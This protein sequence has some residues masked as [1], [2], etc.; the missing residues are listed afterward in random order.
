MESNELGEGNGL[1]GWNGSGMASEI[2]ESWDSTPGSA[3]AGTGA[4]CDLER[5]S[6]LEAAGVSGLV[7]YRWQKLSWMKFENLAKAN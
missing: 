5:C 1:G 3:S 4:D 2:L 6:L 7:R